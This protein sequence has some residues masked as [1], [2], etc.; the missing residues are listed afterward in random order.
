VL[1]VPVRLSDAATMDDLGL[2]HAPPPVEPDDVVARATGP[3]LR[4]VAVLAPVGSPVVPALV[5][6]ESD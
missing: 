5:S 2:V 4:V 3:L 6:R 1:G